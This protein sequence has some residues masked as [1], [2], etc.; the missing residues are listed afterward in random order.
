LND[1][2]KLAGVGMGNMIMNLFGLSTVY[3]MN[4]AME[5]LVA[6]AFGH[7]NLHL[8]GVYLNRARLILCIV[9]IPIIIILFFAEDILLFIN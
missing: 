6:H 2:A 7:G 4:G 5:T 9:Y 1:P 3:G 8:C